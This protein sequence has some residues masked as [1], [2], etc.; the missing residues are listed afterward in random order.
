MILYRVRD[1]TEYTGLSRKQLF[2]YEESI[3]PIE[4]EN[5]AGYKIYDQDGFEKLCIASL[6]SE[7]GMGPKKINAIFSADNFDQNKVLNELVV[8]AK[9]ELQR[10]SDIVV[11]SEF[12]AMLDLSNMPA[13][14]LKLCDLHSTANRIRKKKKSLDFKKLCELNDDNQKKLNKIL[15]GFSKYISYD[16]SSKEVR[17]Q[18]EKL[19]SF[20]EKD[21]QLDN[22]YAALTDFSVMDCMNADINKDLDD[23]F[24]IGVKEYIASAISDYQRTNFF[25]S[26][27]GIEDLYEEAVTLDLDSPKV[28]KVISFLFAQVKKWYG[29]ETM[30]DAAD[31]IKGMDFIFGQYDD[32]D[33]ILE[34]FFKFTA[35]A[36]LHYSHKGN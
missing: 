23:S 19:I 31:Y 36:L 33:E 30:K 3:P 14:P 27:E 24:G 7:L 6:L 28:E 1:I 5:E 16:L 20:F 26:L 21:I 9:K 12:F 35:N 18:V 4:Y 13:N 17:K 32:Y 34:Q 15:K 10:I 11:V 8:S 2:D 22:P 25:E 29:I